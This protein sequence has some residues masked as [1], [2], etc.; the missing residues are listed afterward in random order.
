MTVTLNKEKPVGPNA[1]ALTWSSDDSTAVFDVYVNGQLVLR[2]TKQRSLT[3]AARPDEAVVVDVF[4]DPNDVP[5]YARS[6]VG[7]VAFDAVADTDYRIE[8]LEG[9]EWELE[10]LVGFDETRQQI[11][12]RPI[13]EDG[14]SLRVTAINS[15][16]QEGGPVAVS[17]DIVRHPDPPVVDVVFSDSTKKVT[18][19]AV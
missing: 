9:A 17:A 6:T 8:R 12:T 7:R 2:G 4:D 1:V 10:R 16:G 15:D 19:S 14:E 13:S 5:D 3:L 11:R 18:V